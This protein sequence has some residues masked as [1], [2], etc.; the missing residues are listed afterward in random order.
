MN[1]VRN[2][3]R[4]KNPIVFIAGLTLPAFAIFIYPDWFQPDDLD[5]FL[6]WSQDWAKGAQTIYVNC[7]YCNYPFLGMAFSA[8]AVDWLGIRDFDG[9]MGLFRYY[10]ALIDSLNVAALYYLLKTLAVKDSA[11]WAGVVGLLP[12]SW[13]G[14]S[15]WGQIENFG[16]L[17]ILGFLL[18]A[19][20]INKIPESKSWRTYLLAFTLGFLLSCLLMTKQLVFFSVISLGSM[21]VA[22]LVLI[23]RKR[24]RALLALTVL[25]LSFA[26][27]ILLVDSLLKYDSQYL[28]HL[29]YV[30]AAGSSHGDTISS[31]GFNIWT[32]FTDD[33]FGSSH[34]TMSVFGLN[35]IPYNAGIALF[36]LSILLLSV[37]A[38]YFHIGEYKTG[39]RSFTVR[40]LC[41]WLVHLALVNLS[42]NL[43]LTGTHER[44]LYHFYP[45]AIASVLFLQKMEGVN[46]AVLLGGATF[47][48]VFLYGYLTGYNLNFDQLP[49]RIM[50]VL[51]VYLLVFFT[52]VLINVFLKQRST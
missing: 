46:R 35:L 48:G 2:A 32:L 41:F 50:T 45:F 49:Y 28:S 12:S 11:F 3:I 6:R 36:L 18:L 7:M 4:Y 47:Y 17:F 22:N 29:H 19:A 8:G 26:A 25:A 39:N 34:E 33:P 27:P 44:Y 10:L 15:Y 30:L 14:T 40:H 52:G 43:F 23:S 51:H 31:F 1:W 13:I 37:A 38:I 24:I 42:F 9:M 16:Q 21:A 5:A 20:I